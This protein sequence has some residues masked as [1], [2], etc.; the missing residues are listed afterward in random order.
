MILKIIDY[1]KTS[2][3]SSRGL[4][5][6]HLKS[7]NL[8]DQVTPDINT[9]QIGFSDTDHIIFYSLKISN[10]GIYKLEATSSGLLSGRSK[11]LKISDLDFATLILTSNV[12]SPSAYF[13]FQINAFLKDQSG[14]SW[15]QPTELFVT[16]S[17]I[18][19]GTYRATSYEGIAVFE[20]ICK[21]SGIIPF[22]V[23]GGNVQET[24]Y[25]EIKKLALKIEL[26]TPEVIIT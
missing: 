4:F 9:I 3:L 10:S 19:N 23:T 7:K 2:T 17:E 21:A 25:I 20:I 5:E 24:I 1:N 18:I 12:I 11:D 26:M 22:T 15:N 6:I 8:L 14:D 13:P 16:S